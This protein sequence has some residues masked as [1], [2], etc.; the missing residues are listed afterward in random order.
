MNEWVDLG[1][2][3]RYFFARKTMFV[4]YAS[5]FIVLPGGFGTFDELFESL[6]LV[7]TQKVTVVPDRADRQVLL[8]A[9]A[10]LDPHHGGRRRHDRRRR[11]STCSP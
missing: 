2:H 3:F 10:G 6:T 9:A 1:V 8:G 4:K 11:M 7:Q 5:G